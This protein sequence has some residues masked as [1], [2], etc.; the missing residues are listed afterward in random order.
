MRASYFFKFVQ[1][2]ENDL[3]I[4][5][6]WKPFLVEFEEKPERILKI[7]TISTGDVWKEVDVVVFNTWHWWFHR[8]Q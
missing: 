8:V 6:N 3:S 1:D 7:D 4:L 5:F 2:P